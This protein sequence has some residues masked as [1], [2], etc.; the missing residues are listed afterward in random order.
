MSSLQSGKTLAHYRI[1][2]KIGQGA[3]GE[4]YK[5]EDLKLGRQVAIKL[6][7]PGG[8]TDEKARQRFLRE[9]RPGSALNHPNIITIHAIEESD[10]LD[11]IVSGTAGRQERDQMGRA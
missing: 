8:P 3:M 9:A 10:G 5:A 4:V 1:I 7:P 2:E 6:L 11:F